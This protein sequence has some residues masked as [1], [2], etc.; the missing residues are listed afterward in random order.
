MFGSLQ[1]WRVASSS[2]IHLL[3]NGSLDDE[4]NGAIVGMAI[5]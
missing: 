3:A 5:N 1:T 4:E 2:R